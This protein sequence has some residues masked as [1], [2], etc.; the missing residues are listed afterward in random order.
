MCFSKRIG[1]LLAFRHFVLCCAQ[2]RTVFTPVQLRFAR[3]INNCVILRLKKK[4]ASKV[5]KCQEKLAEVIGKNSQ[6]KQNGWQKQNGRQIM[7]RR[8]KFLEKKT[9]TSHELSYRTREKNYTGMNRITVCYLRN[10]NQTY[11]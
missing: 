3:D 2:C 1:R 8:R 6:Q 9:G 5:R 4:V 10:W 11:R 7:D